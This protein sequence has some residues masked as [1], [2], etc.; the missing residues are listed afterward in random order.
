MIFENGK[1]YWIKYDDNTEWEVARFQYNDKIA[2]LKNGRFRFT[3]GSFI[4]NG[5]RV[6]EAVLV[7]EPDAV[8]YDED[9]LRDAFYKG[10]ETKK[11]PDGVTI[12]IR[13]TFN[14]YLRELDG[15]EDPYENWERRMEEWRTYPPEC[16]C[17]NHVNDLI[18][19]DTTD[20]D[21]EG[22]RH[23]RKCMECNQIWGVSKSHFHRIHGKKSR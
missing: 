9:D 11:L 1:Y 8:T 6:K 14:G 2:E 18:I 20:G 13:P 19:L 16:E 4:S 7:K 21:P 5:S 10:R 15:M 3:N 12:F 17:K 23:D 22:I